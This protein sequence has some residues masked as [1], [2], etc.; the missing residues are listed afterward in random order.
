MF[1]ALLERSLAL[2]PVKT[3]ETDEKGAGLCSP[4]E[5]SLHRCGS[6]CFTEVLQMLTSVGLSY[7]APLCLWR[8]IHLAANILVAQHSVLRFELIR[9]LRVRRMPLP[10]AVLSWGP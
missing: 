4:A 8:E 9:L 2:S 10:H 6:G 5:G 7:G 3:L 1:E